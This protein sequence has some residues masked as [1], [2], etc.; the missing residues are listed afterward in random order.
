[1]TSRRTGRALEPLEGRTNQPRLPTYILTL[2]KRTLQ[3]LSCKGLLSEVNSA[4]WQFLTHV[5]GKRLSR[6]SFLQRAS[7]YRDLLIY[8]QIFVAQVTRTALNA[9]NLDRPWQV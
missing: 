6:I 2:C 3:Q 1:M 4:G 5:V 7:S 8:R 9:T